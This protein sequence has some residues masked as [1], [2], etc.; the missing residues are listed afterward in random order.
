MQ[1]RALFKY[2]ATFNKTQVRIDFLL[3][4]DEMAS[5]ILIPRQMIADREP[6]IAR[7]FVDSSEIDCIRL[8]D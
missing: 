3:H 1:L 8:I 5:F 4:K 2:L 6:Q 7:N